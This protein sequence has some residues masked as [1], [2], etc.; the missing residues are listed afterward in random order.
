MATMTSAELRERFKVGD[1]VRFETTAGG[2]VEVRVDTPL[3]HA[4]VALQGA[5]VIEWQPHGG[6]PVLFISS[7]SL[8]QPGKAIRGGVPLIFPWFGAKADDP[9]APQHGFARSSEWQLGAV[10]KDA[11]GAVRLTL[12]LAADDATRRVWPHD[13]TARYQVVIGETLEMALE[14]ENTSSHPFSFEEALHTYLAVADAREI[15]VTGLAGT[16]YIDK[17]DGFKR[18]R[19]EAPQIRLSGETDSV[20]LDTPATCVVD[21]AGLRR[22]LVVDK[23]GSVSTVVWNPWQ[24]KAGGMSD[25]GPDEWPKM[26]CVETANAADNAVRLS[27][28]ER[29]TMRAV[30]RAEPR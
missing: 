25:F 12:A 17:V 29:H 9:K 1:D 23:S 4:R 13:F 20:Y 26:V 7:R 30:V 15:A 16:T 3:A 22:R 10:A 6:A 11:K 21:D 18:K 5:H 28:G 8:F 24:E 27:A 19:Q 14:V 2:L